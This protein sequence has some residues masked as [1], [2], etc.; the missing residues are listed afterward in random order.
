MVCPACSSLSVGPLATARRRFFRCAA[1]RF[2][3]AAPE[4]RPTEAEARARYA[5]HRNSPLDRGYVAYLGDILATTAAA[6]G[7]ASGRVVDWGSG[8]DPVFAGAL[9]R[10]GYSVAAW[11]PLFA[12]AP[13]PEGDRDLAFCIEVA[14]HFFDPRKDFAALAATLAPGGWAALHTHPA[15][16]DDAEFLAWWYVEDPTHV[17]FYTDAAIAALARS[18]DLI[19]AGRPSEKLWLLRRQASGASDSR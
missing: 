11:D 3:W 6:T 4:C 1:C 13:P 8:P 19:P 18:A 12:A 5:K 17:S 10:A 16:E 2:A 7:V 9:E 14:E 15:P